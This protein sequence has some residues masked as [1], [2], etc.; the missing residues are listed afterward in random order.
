MI[1]LLIFY[2]FGVIIGTIIGGQDCS[3]PMIKPLKT[4]PIKV[5]PLVDRRPFLPWEIRRNR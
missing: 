2:G 3:K 1:N 5:R 4:K